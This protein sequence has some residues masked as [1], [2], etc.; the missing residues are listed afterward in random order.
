MT[1]T[2]HQE[3]LKRKAKRV[4]IQAQNARFIKQFKHNGSGRILKVFMADRSRGYQ[5]NYKRVPTYY[6]LIYDNGELIH[7]QTMTQ[8]E[9]QKKEPEFNA[10]CS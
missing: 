3:W 10:I 6:L 5:T 1:D 8:R 9:W 4:A 7:G 2:Y